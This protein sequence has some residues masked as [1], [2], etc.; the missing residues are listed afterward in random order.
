MTR[1]AMGPNRDA[2]PACHP[3]LP[4]LV[5]SIAIAF[6]PGDY[7]P[8]EQVRNTTSILSVWTRGKKVNEGPLPRRSFTTP[9]N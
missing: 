6:V 7:D 1:I 4:G 8:S 5:L 3:F 9:S 2:R